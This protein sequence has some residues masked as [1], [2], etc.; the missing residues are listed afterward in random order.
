MDYLSLVGGAFCRG[1]AAQAP[2]RVQ[3][4]AHRHVRDDLVAERVDHAN[5]RRGGEGASGGGVL[6]SERFAL[7]GYL[8]SRYRC[9]YGRLRGVLRVTL[10]ENLGSR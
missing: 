10:A 8:G 6:S 3:R 9:T 2:R 5:H 4:D 7:P 1:R